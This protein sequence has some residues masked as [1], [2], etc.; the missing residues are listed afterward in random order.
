MSAEDGL[1]RKTGREKDRFEQEDLGF[2]QR[3]RQGYLKLAANE[4]GRWLVVDAT[5]SKQK[6]AGIIWEK[7]RQ[8]LSSGG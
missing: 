5:Q 4:P 1:A 8:L 7:V 3:V 6:I 2:H